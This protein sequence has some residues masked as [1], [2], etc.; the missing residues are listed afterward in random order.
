MSKQD[1]LRRRLDVEVLELEMLIK[2]MERE[3]QSL[4][5]HVAE[6][7]ALLAHLREI[8]SQLTPPHTA[9]H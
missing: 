4:A 9:H 3:Q 5:E 1:E 7:R 8:Q 2:E 6:L